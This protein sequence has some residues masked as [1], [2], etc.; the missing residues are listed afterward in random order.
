MAIPKNSGAA[1]A[2]VA[3]TEFREGPPRSRKVPK[4]SYLTA[5]RVKPPVLAYVSVE[6]GPVTPGEVKVPWPAKSPLRSI[7]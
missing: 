1:H 4:G 2:H 3:R 6:E 7:F 5:L